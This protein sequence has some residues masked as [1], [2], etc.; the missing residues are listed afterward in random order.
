MTD[1][2]VV[3]RGFPRELLP[4]AA[5]LYD[6]AFGEKL[7]RAMPDPVARRSVLRDVLDPSH[8]LVALRGGELVGIAGFK[9]AAG[10]LAGG[11]TLGRLR[12]RLGVVGALRAAMVLVLFERRPVPGQLLMD[13]I[14]V[15]PALRGAGI[16][17][18]LLRGLVD[19]A[20]SAG[21]RSIRRDVIDTNPAARRLYERMGF[22]AV[23]T[24][25][26][27]YLGWLLGFEAATQMELLVGAEG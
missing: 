4:A 19:Y 18:M 3:Q 8:A 27:A 2:I 22:V 15:A 5:E 9:T 21:Y 24:Q 14:G 25:R 16:G 23:G 11:F 7:S 10:S 26:F 1:T 20:R 13:G 6:A 12:A 17:T